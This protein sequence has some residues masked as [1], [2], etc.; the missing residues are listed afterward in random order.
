MT[1]IAGFCGLCA[2]SGVWPAIDTVMTAGLLGLAGLALA[3]H[4]ARATVREL[5]FRRYLNNLDAH[6]AARPTR[7]EIPA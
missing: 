3:G 2:A 6:D 5:R 7:E 4:L 1:S